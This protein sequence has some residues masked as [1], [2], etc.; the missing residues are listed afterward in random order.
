M[1]DPVEIINNKLEVQ[2]FEHVEDKIKLLG[3]FKSEDSECKL[4]GTPCLSVQ[5]LDFQQ[6][7]L[8]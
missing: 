4:S 7:V 2:A 6:G 5:G 1:E 8:D 3:F